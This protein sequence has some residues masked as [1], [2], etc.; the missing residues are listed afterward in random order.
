VGEADLTGLA[1]TVLLADG[2]QRSIR[3]LKYSP[4]ADLLRGFPGPAGFLAPANTGPSLARNL[5]ADAGKETIGGE[6]WHASIGDWS[7]CS[8]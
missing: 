6:P 5:L 2:P 7:C 4:N 1:P 8:A 3:L